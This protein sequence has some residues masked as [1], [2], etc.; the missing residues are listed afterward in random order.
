[1]SVLVAPQQAVEVIAESALDSSQ[2]MF[3]IG[4][5]ADRV[6]VYSQQHRA[7]NLIWALTTTNHITPAA[8][9]AVIGAGFAGLAAAA[10]LVGTGATVH[11]IERS[12]EVLPLQRGCACR[13]LHPNMYDW[14]SL[15]SLDDWTRLPF[16]NWHV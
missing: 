2:R 1:M 10:A 6:T 4:C 5:F 3:S 8:T 9:V 15:E 7:L 16:M 11:L 14:P 13:Y 12:S